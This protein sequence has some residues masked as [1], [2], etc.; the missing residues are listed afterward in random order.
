MQPADLFL[1][2]MTRAASESY[3][4]PEISE[5]GSAKGG[6]ELR[7]IGCAGYTTTVLYQ[8]LIRIKAPDTQNVICF[9]PRIGGQHRAAR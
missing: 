1:G 4:E 8:W 7:N 3:S 9:N 5:L 2:L 6:W